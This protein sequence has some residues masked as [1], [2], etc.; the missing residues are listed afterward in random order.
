MCAMVLGAKKRGCVC[1]WLCTMCINVCIQ[2]IALL[3]LVLY[4]CEVLMF[5]LIHPSESNRAVNIVLYCVIINYTE[6][7]TFEVS[8]EIRF[9]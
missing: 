4:F 8:F 1:V 2:D 6:S 3:N 7:N 5:V 9:T